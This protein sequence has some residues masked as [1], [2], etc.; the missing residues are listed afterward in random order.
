MCSRRQVE[1][2]R[3]LVGVDRLCEWS[4]F[5]ATEQKCIVFPVRY[6]ISLYVEESRP[7]P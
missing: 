3:V 7:P 1:I 6:E 2:V 5:L 4:E